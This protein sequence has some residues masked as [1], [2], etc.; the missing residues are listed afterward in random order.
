MAFP[1]TRLA[2]TVLF[3]GLS[4]ALS[5]GPAPESETGPGPGPVPESVRKAFEL[6]PFYRQYTSLEGLPIVASDE[7]SPSA[8]REAK[9][10]L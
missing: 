8:L 2:A 3:A 10:I 4:A 1:H 9:W 6:P 5:P 7:P